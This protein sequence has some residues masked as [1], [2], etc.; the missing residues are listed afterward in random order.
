LRPCHNP[1]LDRRVTPRPA[2][3]EFTPN[4]ACA[5][6]GVEGMPDACVVGASAPVETVVLLGD[7]HGDHWRAAM[8]ALALRRNWRVVELA[9][10][11]CPFTFALQAVTP[12]G[13]GGQW[14]VD[15]D[16]TVVDWLAAHPE[17]SRVFVSNKSRVTMVE[18]GF[19]YRTAGDQQALSS[20]PASVTRIYVLR[21]VPVERLTAHSCVE[22]AI[23]RHRAPG[24]RCET[25][26]SLL[27]RD[28]TASAARRLYARGARVIDLTHFFCS[29][30]ECF[31]VVGGVLTHKDRDH[32]TRAFSA[33]LGPYLAR[34][35]HAAG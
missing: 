28:P 31:P 34:G 4:V 24:R 27:V 1:R 20:L 2:G 13:A 30:R 10:G 32:M 33:T 29:E 18:K 17:I 25:A 22:R 19:A 5:S 16:H 21:D 9:L 14:C 15:Y 35:V 3:A 26:R 12:E 8:K 11:H 7:S 6:V 23:A